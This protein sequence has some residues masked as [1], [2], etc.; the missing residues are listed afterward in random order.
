MPLQAAIMFDRSPVASRGLNQNL[1]L[2]MMQAGFFAGPALAG[3]LLSS[4]GFV[5]LFFGAALAALVAALATIALR[6]FSNS[7]QPL[8]ERS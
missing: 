4:A 5:G 3:V 6:F 2:S 1:M 8:L 7:C